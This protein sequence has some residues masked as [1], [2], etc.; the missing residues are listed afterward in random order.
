MSRSKSLVFGMA[1]VIAM[2]ATGA[3]AQEEAAAAEE[4]KPWS[5]ELGA[6]YNSKYVWRGILLTD[7]PVLQPS[8]TFAFKGFSLDI[9]ANMDL[10]DVNGNNDEINEVDYTLDYS[11]EAGPIGYSVGVIYYDFPN[12]DFAST[13]EVYTGIGLKDV[14]L[15]PTLTVYRD[16]D[17]VDGFYVTLDVSHSFE[18]V[19]TF[20]ETAAM[21]VDLGAQV[22]WGDSDY[23]SGY[24][25]VDDDGFNTLTLTAG[26][27]FAIGDHL[28]ITLA[29]NYTCLVDGDIR[30][31]TSDED[32]FWAGVSV[33]LSF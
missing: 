13:T 8:I 1:V 2:L 18:N 32:N 20:S 31:T 26:L 5:I 12:T 22:S 17:E 3:H 11:G 33:G 30:D 9:W 7:D 4:E 14:P 10:T 27:P 6:D 23:N 25:G 16:V 28:T 29:V 21:A 24:L 19:V 15:T